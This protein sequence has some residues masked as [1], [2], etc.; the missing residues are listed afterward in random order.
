M[1]GSPDLLAIWQIDAHAGQ[2]TGGGIESV[3][4]EMDRTP[5]LLRPLRTYAAS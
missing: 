4:I 1:T 5:T 2:E 3:C